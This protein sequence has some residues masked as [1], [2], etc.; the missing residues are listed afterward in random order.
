ML[1]RSVTFNKIDAISEA[2]LKKKLADFKKRVKLTPV[3]M[4]GA[5]GK[6]VDEMMKKLLTIINADKR[7]QRKADAPGVTSE[8]WR[9]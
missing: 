4:S 2:D 8:E 7:A 3:L 6:G 5:T 9:P 1:F